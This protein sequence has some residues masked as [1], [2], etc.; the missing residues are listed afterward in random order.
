MKDDQPSAYMREVRDRLEGLDPD[1][2]DEAAKQIVER[3]RKFRDEA[4]ALRQAEPDADNPAT[5]HKFIAMAE[6]FKSE[7]SLALKTAHERQLR[8]IALRKSRAP[9]QATDAQIERWERHARHA[10]YEQH[11]KI[12]QQM[13]E[14]HAA[15][16]QKAPGAALNEKHSLE[17][18]GPP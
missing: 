16:W 4:V 7:T 3:Y 5:R 8:Q 18:R 17:R 12:G 11:E 14:R 10:L 2:C 1:I 15:E 6:S 9:V 13:A